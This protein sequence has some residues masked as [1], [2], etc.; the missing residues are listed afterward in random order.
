MFKGYKIKF[1]FLEKFVI[2]YKRLAPEG[3]INITENVR[4]GSKDI[5]W[6]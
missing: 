3:L 6:S 1:F 5:K 2:F 4:F